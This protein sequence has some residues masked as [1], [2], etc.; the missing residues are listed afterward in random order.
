MTFISL[1]CFSLFPSPSLLFLS[2]SLSS[3]LSGQNDFKQMKRGV[4]PM[5]VFRIQQDIS[6]KPGADVINKLLQYLGFLQWLR[7]AI[8]YMLE[9]IMIYR[10]ANAV[11]GWK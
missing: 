10:T 7:I 8:I 3:F 11:G 1:S 2:F 4:R 6:V 9:S 5:L